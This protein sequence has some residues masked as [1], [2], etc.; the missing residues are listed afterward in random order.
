MGKR[1][2][3]TVSTHPDGS[4]TATL[5]TYDTDGTPIATTTTTY[6]ADDAVTTTHIEE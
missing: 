3:R 1:S 2:D 5:T 6:G 4:M